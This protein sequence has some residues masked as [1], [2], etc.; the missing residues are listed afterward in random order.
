MSQPA[1]MRGIVASPPDRFKDQVSGIRDQGSGI[2]DQ[3]SGI[4]YQKK[5]PAASP[6]RRCWGAG[7]YLPS[8]L[9]AANFF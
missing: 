9:R 5:L 7:F 1:R 4:R 6:P 3:V 8:A 2:R